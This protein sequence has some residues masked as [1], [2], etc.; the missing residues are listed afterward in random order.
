MTEDE[1][2]GQRHR[3]DQHEFNPTP[4]GS[5]RQEGLAASSP[6]DHKDPDTA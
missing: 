2:D 5:G 1:V 6:W 4:G 3:S